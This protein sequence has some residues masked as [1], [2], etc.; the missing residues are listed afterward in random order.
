M[1]LELEKNT[2]ESGKYLLQAVAAAAA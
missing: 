2:S 1:H